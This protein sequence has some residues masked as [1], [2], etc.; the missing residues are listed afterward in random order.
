MKIACVFALLAAAYAASRP[1]EIPFEK[2]TIDLG[3]YET[4]AFADVNRDGRLDIVSGENCYEG[5]AWVKHRF[6]EIEYGRN[7]TEDLTVSIW[8]GSSPRL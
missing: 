4:C 5:P 6:R 2:R 1:G 3:A 7:A 8:E